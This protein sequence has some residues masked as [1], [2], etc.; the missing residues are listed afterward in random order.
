M[1]DRAQRARIREERHQR[2]QSYLLTGTTPFLRRQSAPTPVTQQP[3]Y[4]SSGST[5]ATATPLATY[6]QASNPNRNVTNATRN[7]GTQPESLEYIITDVL[8]FPSDGIMA[9][10]MEQF[11]V[12]RSE[13]RR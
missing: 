9:D 12:N 2:R 13:E 7:P 6:V 8:G 11:G 5:P 3:T 10:A 4:A 1:T